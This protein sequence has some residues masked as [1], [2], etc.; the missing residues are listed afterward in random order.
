VEFGDDRGFALVAHGEVGIVPLAHHAEALELL[1]LDR[2][3]LLGKGA[4]FGAELGGGDLVLAQLLLAIGFLDLPFDRQ[5]VAVPAGNV[6]RVIAAQGRRADHDVLQ[7][8][9]HGVAH[10]E[11][12]IGVR[13]AIV[14]DEAFGTGTGAA[15]LAVRSVSAQRARMAGSFAARPAFIGKSVLGRKTVSL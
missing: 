13:R 7:D 5:A 6:G 8:L 3:P 1:A 14:K 10:V 9:V 15:K 4:A 12:A 11:I 2:H